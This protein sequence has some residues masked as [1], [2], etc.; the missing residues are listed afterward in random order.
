LRKTLRSQT[1]ENATVTTHSSSYD[2]RSLPSLGEM[3][4]S[5]SHEPL[6]SGSSDEVAWTDDVGPSHV[7]PKNADLEAHP[8]LSG[9][10]TSPEPETTAVGP[11][12][13][14]L[15]AGQDL[16]NVVLP[17]GLHYD[18]IFKGEAPGPYTQKEMD[19][20][21][22]ACVLLDSVRRMDLAK[23]RS[24]STHK[25]AQIHHTV[26]DISQ[27]LNQSKYKVRRAGKRRNAAQQ[28]TT[29]AESESPL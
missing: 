7:S 3:T 24:S 1:H 29:S 28:W 10:G 12:F 18:P 5:G 16:N 11:S 22:T 21:D 23:V 26:D 27:I 4:D 2:G 20:L 13:A 19:R 8:Q 17:T 14:Q 25:T 9:H 6:T 15:S